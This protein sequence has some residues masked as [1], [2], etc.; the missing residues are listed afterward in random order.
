MIFVKLA[1]SLSSAWSNKAIKE[2]KNSTQKNIKGLSIALIRWTA[3]VSVL[4]T[5]VHANYEDVLQGGT[6]S[7]LDGNTIF[8][9][10]VVLFFAGLYKMA[11]LTA[12]DSHL[13]I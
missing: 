9:P 4:V 1:L 11:Y 10:L 7:V 2:M 12:K 8:V 6:N 3:L 5:F 13:A